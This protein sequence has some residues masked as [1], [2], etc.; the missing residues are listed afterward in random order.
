[1]L[2]IIGLVAIL[3]LT[4]LLGWADEPRH[5]ILFVSANGNYEAK[6][7][8]DRVW[9]I[10]EKSTGEEIY[11]IGDYYRDGIW[12][13]SMTLVISDDG[14]SVVA[15]NDYAEQ[16]SQK[17]PDVLFFFK[18]GQKFKSYKLLDLV[19]PRFMQ[20]SVSHFWWVD[21]VKKFLISD[22][23]IEFTTLDMN[24]FVFNIDDGLLISK[25]TDEIFAKGAIFVYGEVRSL[26]KNRYEIVVDCS[27]RGNTKTGDKISF[28]SD[29]IGWEGR[30][31]NEALILQDGHLV[32]RKGLIFN[33]CN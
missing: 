9:R 13:S 14:R 20:F 25:S 33:N 4:S 2:R 22:S 8:E 19:N 15:V 3:L 6:L 26:T 29:K 23:K 24:H 1:M 5:Q 7:Q 17:N 21:S 31:F 18:D 27:V 16:D 30:G 11:R 32:A 10:A 28:E 12:F